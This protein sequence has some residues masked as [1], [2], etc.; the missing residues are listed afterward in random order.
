MLKPWAV[1]CDDPLPQCIPFFNML[2]GDEM[3]FLRTLSMQP[4][5]A[6]TTDF[7]IPGRETRDCWEKTWGLTFK[8]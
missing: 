5:I 1:S 4:L 8:V 6:T 7:Y 3:I 2:T